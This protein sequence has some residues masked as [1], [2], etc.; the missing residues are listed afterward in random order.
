MND[1]ILRI[2]NK[3]VTNVDKRYAI[4]LLKNRTGVATVVSKLT[5]KVFCNIRMVF[6][7]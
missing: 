4:G 6:Q 5:V 3:D 7:I 2:N 1:Q